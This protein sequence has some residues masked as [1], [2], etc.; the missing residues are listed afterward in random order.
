MIHR[1]IKNGVAE[2]CPGCELCVHMAR[3]EKKHQNRRA[4]CL[5]LILVAVCLVLA[6]SFFHFLIGL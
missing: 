1:I 2:D 3:A 4:C 5:V 6:N